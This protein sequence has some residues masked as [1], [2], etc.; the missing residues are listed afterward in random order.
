MTTVHNNL[1]VVFAKMA[2][3][4]EELDGSQVREVH[5]DQRLLGLMQDLSSRVS[6]TENYAFNMN[7]V[8][9]ALQAL[10]AGPEFP[11]M[12]S[13]TTIGVTSYQRRD[14]NWNVQ[15]KGLERDHVRV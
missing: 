9:H 2:F 4:E 3:T 14:L 15:D 10:T 1:R 13:P 11:E 8:M 5:R 6:T 7:E 12:P